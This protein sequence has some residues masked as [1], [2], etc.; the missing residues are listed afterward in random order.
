MIKENHGGKIILGGQTDVNDRYISPTII[1]SPKLDST[2]MLEEIFGPILPILEFSEFD[3][4]I[5]FVN[6]REKPLALYY[7][8][9][10]S[11]KNKDRIIN[12]TSS[13][14][15][16]VNDALFHITNMDLPFGGVGNSG[17]SALHGKWGFRACSHYKPIFNKA[18]LNGG[19][20]AARY[21]PY[22]EKK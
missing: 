12:E 13:G 2:V 21:P 6:E 5:K 10:G 22:T 18:T 1:D 20:F 3:E 17:T 8:G 19:P 14:A 4:V 16:G 7:F 11:G 15:V 9:S